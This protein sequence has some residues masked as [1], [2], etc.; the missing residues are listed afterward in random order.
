MQPTGDGATGPA[1]PGAT[2]DAGLDPA[3]HGD[4]GSPIGKPDASIPSQDSAAPP[5]PSDD[6]S[7][8]PTHDASAPPGPSHDASA[9]PPPPPPS[10]FPDS[11]AGNPDGPP[12]RRQCTSSLGSGLSASHARLDGYIVAVIPP[13]QGKQCNGDSSHVHLQVLMNNQVYDVA[14]NTNGQGQM[15][16]KDEA[17]LGGPWAEG[18]HT[19]DALDYP[20]SLGV[21]AAGFSTTTATAVENALAQANHVSIFCTGYGSTGCHLVHR[22]GTGHDGAIVIDPLSPT[23]KWLLFDFAGDNF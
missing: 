15:T 7:L 2:S 23:S 4:G 5:Q 20:T 21:H 13:G 11:G 19:Q 6:A 9:P 1:A 22:Q 17:L 8:P 14:V 3:H 18:W 16:T 10:P 12:T